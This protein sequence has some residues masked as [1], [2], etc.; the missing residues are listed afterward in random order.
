MREMV[1][2]LV[3]GVWFDGEVL[4]VLAGETVVG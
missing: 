2:L 4:V 3:G 1:V